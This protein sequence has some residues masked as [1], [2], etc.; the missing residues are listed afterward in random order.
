MT[1]TAERHDS[2]LHQLLCHNAPAPFAPVF[3]V[4]GNDSIVMSVQDEQ[5]LTPR[6]HLEYNL[7]EYSALRATIRERGTARFCIF[8]FGIAAWGALA[9]ATAALATAPVATLLPLVVLGGVFEA[10]YA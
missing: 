4:I 5:Q 6:E 10:V 8:A 9:I 3:P 2:A 1:V 7:L